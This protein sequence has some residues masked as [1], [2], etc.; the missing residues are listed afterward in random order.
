MPFSLDDDCGGFLSFPFV[1]HLIAISFY[2]QQNG[3]CV[4]VYFYCI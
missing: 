1:V 2:Q 4:N 3:K